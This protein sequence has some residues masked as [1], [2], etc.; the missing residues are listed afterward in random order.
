MS[1]IRGGARGD[2]Y[3]QL[4]REDRVH[5]RLYTDPEIFAEEM[6]KVFGGVWVYV[7]HASELR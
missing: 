2:L 5:R 1:T 7:G 4:V 3:D 6:V